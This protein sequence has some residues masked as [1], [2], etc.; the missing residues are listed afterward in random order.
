MNF[1]KY[2]GQFVSITIKD[3]ESSM[4]ADFEGLLY[5]I[6]DDDWLHIIDE[7][8]DESA[9]NGCNVINIDIVG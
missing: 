8:E 5:K 9:I 6:S 4:T 7:D 1:D 3:R 2:L